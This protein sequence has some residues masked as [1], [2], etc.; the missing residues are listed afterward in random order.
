MKVLYGIAGFVIGV[1]AGLLLGVL[2][3]KLLIHLHQ[4]TIIPFVIGGTVLVCIVTGVVTGIQ[5]AKH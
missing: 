2:E 5:I 3:T 1:M 4:Q